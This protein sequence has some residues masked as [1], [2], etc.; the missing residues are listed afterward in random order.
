MQIFN[1]CLPILLWQQGN[2]AR[3]TPGRIMRQS[4][5]LPQMCT[6]QHRDIC[7]RR[8][9]PS[10]RRQTQMPAKQLDV[11]CKTHIPT[12]GGTQ[13]CH[14]EQGSGKWR[15]EELM[16]TGPCPAKDDHAAKR[17]MRDSAPCTWGGKLNK[18]TQ[19]EEKKESR[20]PHSATYIIL[21]FIHTKQGLPTL[22]KIRQSKRHPSEQ[23][24]VVGG[25]DGG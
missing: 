17:R 11:V 10:H 15:G 23:L 16:R 18:Q 7:T 1:A 24:L 22:G 20:L 4:Q 13:T 5:A 25:R 14:W 21:E 19:N 3:F 9:V 12:E 6:G 2:P 8:A